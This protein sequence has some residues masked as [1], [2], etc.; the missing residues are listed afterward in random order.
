MTLGHPLGPLDTDRMVCGTSR[1]GA[2]LCPAGIHFC[3]SLSGLSH[4]ACSPRFHTG[5]SCRVTAR[6]W[7]S[8]WAPSPTARPPQSPAGF[9]LTSSVSNNGGAPF[10]LG[11]EQV[12]ATPCEL[13]P[14]PA[15]L[16]LGTGEASSC[17][18]FPIGGPT[19]GSPTPLFGLKDEDGVR[20]RGINRDAPA[21]S[22][23]PVAEAQRGGQGALTW[24]G[25]ELPTCRLTR[26]HFPRGGKPIFLT[27]WK[28]SQTEKVK[29]NHL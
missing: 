18:E 27:L 5:E 22:A 7:I 29:R 19:S 16:L 10:P 4:R 13:L 14:K 23:Q 6:W 1:S 21:T 3:S 26:Q 17:A 8:L 28:K 25:V 9:S 2:G 12:C 15:K 20:S 24:L 11:R